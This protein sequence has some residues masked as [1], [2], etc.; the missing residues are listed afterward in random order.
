MDWSVNIKG[1]CLEF[2]EDTHQ[3]L[4][5]GLMVDS[6]T[7]ILS[8][9]YAHKFDGVPDKVLRS[10]A[11]KGTELHEHIER[12]CKE[13]IESELPEFRNFLFLQKQYKFSVLENE[14]PVILWDDRIP[15][16]A[17]RLD[18][19]IN[20]DGK[21]G[22]ADIKRVSV[23]DKAYLADQLNLYRIALKQSYDTDCEFLRGIHLREDVRKFVPIPINE[24]MARQLIK[25]YL[26]GKY[27][28]ET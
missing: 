14:V 6:V 20:M 19:I 21:M 2:I 3:Y 13:G 5:D 9:K 18:M 15:V 7:Q 10:A 11:N 24:A 25:D 12:Y 8:K 1:H 4:V 17:G 27:D 28:T 22:I 26:G 23:L 16:A